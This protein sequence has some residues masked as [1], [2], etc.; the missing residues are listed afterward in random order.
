[1]K[2]QNFFYYQLSV[3]LNEMY[4]VPYMVT[5]KIIKETETNFI[6]EDNNGNKHWFSKDVFTG[7]NFQ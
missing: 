7:K 2:Q 5:G 6:A 3:D 4:C 1:M